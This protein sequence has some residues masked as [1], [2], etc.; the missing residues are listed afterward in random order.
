MFQYLGPEVYFFR[1]NLCNL[2]QKTV[3]SEKDTF[4]LLNCALKVE[5]FLLNSEIDHNFV[6]KWENSEQWWHD[7]LQHWN[8]PF[9]CLQMV[10]FKGSG[11]SSNKSWQVSNPGHPALFGA[12]VPCLKST[13]SVIY[14]YMTDIVW[15]NLERDEIRQKIFYSSHNS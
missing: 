12:H 15:G 11:R 7:S 8:N 5:T 6:I 1:L 2:Y 10:P 9:H 3:L 4:L 13:V 14:V